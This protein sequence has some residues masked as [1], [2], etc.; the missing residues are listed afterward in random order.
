MEKF[1]K[2]VSMVGM[3]VVVGTY[4][5][6][7]YLMKVAVNKLF[8]NDPEGII[9]MMFWLVFTVPSFLYAINFFK[10]PMKK[11]DSKD[12]NK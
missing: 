5:A 1:E 6:M 9:V 7:I 12:G 3:I 2:I 11:W 10:H 8:G 4:V